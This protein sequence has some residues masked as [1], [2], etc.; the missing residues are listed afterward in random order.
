MIYFKH[1]FTFEPEPGKPSTITIV[2]KCP[3]AEYTVKLDETKLLV[4][5]QIFTL[6][7]KLISGTEETV[8][9]TLTQYN[10]FVKGVDI[11]E[12]IPDWDPTQ[13]TDEEPI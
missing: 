10:T 4:A 11:I 7:G 9:I 3:D 2:D 1:T 13:E 8:V 6:Y 12:P 5:Q